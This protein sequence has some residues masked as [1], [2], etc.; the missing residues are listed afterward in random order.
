MAPAARGEVPQGVEE[1]FVRPGFR[2]AQQLPQHVDYPRAFGVHEVG[3]AGGPAGGVQ[4]H[5][6][7]Q[8]SHTVQRFLPFFGLEQVFP[9]A[10]QPF[11][12][13]RGAVG[14]LLEVEQ[15]RVA[16][17]GFDQPGVP[18]GGDRDPIAPPLVRG[19]VRR[20]QLAE[21]LAAALVQP[22]ARVVG[23]GQ[24]S[25]G[26][27]VEQPRKALREVA[28]NLGDVQLAVGE[29]A[30][31]L[32][33]IG[34]GMGD[35]AGH[36]V[37]QRTGRTQ[38]GEVRVRRRLGGIVC[39][40]FGLRLLG[41]GTRRRRSRSGE[42]RFEQPV[43]IDGHAMRARLLFADFVVSQVEAGQGHRHLGHP[44]GLAPR[45]LLADFRAG[46]GGDQFQLARVAER[47]FV[48]GGP[49]RV[50]AGIPEPARA[51]VEHTVAYVGD[52]AAPV[53]KFQGATLAALQRFHQNHQHRVVAARQHLLGGQAG[54]LEGLQGTALVGH[55][56]N[57]EKAGELE[58][59]GARAGLQCLQ[60]NA[61]NSFQG[62][63]GV[64]GRLYAVAV[65][66][67]GRAGRVPRREG[68]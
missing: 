34:N 45:A 40:R 17:Q 10:P 66:A 65:D 23:R 52:D 9:I 26:G 37:G 39:G 68:E 6:Q 42:P 32:G 41:I 55:F 64:D 13:Q 60:L 58:N 19:F 38:G 57:A 8:R 20:D 53:A 36:L 48:V 5:S 30:K 50:Q 43:G 59:Q 1:K 61:A 46:A 33:E 3:I 49:G 22:H 28:G 67:R 21:E 29:G 14:L 56:L 2:V 4:A 35:V 18:V 24:E 62:I 63:V 51:H 7:R 25:V 27:Q 16:G 12:H 11:L 54:V 15:S 47:H 31:E 44:Q